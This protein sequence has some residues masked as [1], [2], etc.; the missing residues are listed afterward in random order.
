MSKVIYFGHVRESLDEIARSLTLAAVLHSFDHLIGGF[1]LNKEVFHAI[2]RAR[3]SA[4]GDF[5]NEQKAV[6]DFL[7]TLLDVNNINS[8]LFV[9]RLYCPQC[10]KVLCENHKSENY[11]MPPQT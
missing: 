10:K 1:Y 7:T 4:T 9:D 2:T 11:K 3:A 5:N 8:H 6:A